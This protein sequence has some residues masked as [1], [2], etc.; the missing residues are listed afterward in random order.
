M[1]HPRGEFIM[2]NKIATAVLVIVLALATVSLVTYWPKVDQE[3]PETP[4][5]F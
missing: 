5:M 3:S 2:M 4:D 1:R